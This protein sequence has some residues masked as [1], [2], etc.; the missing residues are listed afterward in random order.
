MYIVG[1]LWLYVEYTVTKITLDLRTP[2]LASQL[3]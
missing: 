1:E 2:P 3:M